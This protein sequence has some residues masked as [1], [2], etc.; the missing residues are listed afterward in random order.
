MVT[1]EQTYPIDSSPALGRE[2]R[3]AAQGESFTA[4]Q[5]FLEH[6]GV[7]YPHALSTEPDGS[8]RLYPEA[9]GRYVVRVRWRSVSR[10]SGWAQAEFDLDAKRGSTPQRVGLGGLKLWVPTAWDAHLLGTHEPAVFRDLRSF[11]RRGGNVYDIGANVG[12]FSVRLAEWIG[13]EGWLYAIEPNPICV[14]F[15]RANLSKARA[16]N[17]TIIPV[18]VSD[19]PC[20][21]AFSLNYGSSLIGVGTDLPNARKP[22]HQIGVDGDRLDSLITTFRLRPPDFI[23]LDV[24]GAE[25][26]AIAGMRETLETTRPSLMIE[27]H[28]REAATATLQLLAPL[29]YHYLRP[30]TA[31][32][33]D[34]TDA[35]L[36][37]L[38]DECVQIV[39]YP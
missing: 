5:Y 38:E 9:P 39:G 1:I 17:F 34:T 8:I 12:L 36:D 27:L 20:T 3:F 13:A 31:A 6:E 7:L 30:A 16:R 15:L 14:Y 24:E 25:A 10:H 28:G 32:K 23:K 11:V 18:A 29:G 35:L 37:S 19:Q 2:C 33:Y 21:L 26:K 22:G 4:L